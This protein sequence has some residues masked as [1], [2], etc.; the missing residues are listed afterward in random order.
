MNE[1]FQTPLLLI[2]FNRPDH[3]RQVWNEIKKQHPKQVY[4]FGWST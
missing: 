3:T 1:Q 2:C 4:V